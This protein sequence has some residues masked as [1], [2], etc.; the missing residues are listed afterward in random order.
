MARGKALEGR[1]A[2]FL[3]KLFVLW[4]RL[5]FLRYVI[6]DWG[7]ISGNPFYFSTASRRQR[8]NVFLTDALAASGKKNLN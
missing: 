1:S 4:L 5:Q 2:G 8:A 7:I 3:K 6:W